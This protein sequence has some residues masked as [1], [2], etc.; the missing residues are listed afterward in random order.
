MQIYYKDI[1]VKK[2]RIKVKYIEQHLGYICF[3]VL[4]FCFLRTDS[5]LTKF[6]LINKLLSPIGNFF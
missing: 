3:W 2:F 4:F 1:H 6:E 5:D